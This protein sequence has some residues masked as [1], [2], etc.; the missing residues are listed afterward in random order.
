MTTSHPPRLVSIRVWGEFACVTRPELKAERV[1]YPVLTPAAA[2]GILEA[3]YFEPQMSYLIH[4]IGVVK[5]GRWFSFRRNEVSKVVSFRDAARAMDGAGHLATIQAGGGAP[6]ATQR[7][8]LALADVEYL[9][10]A[11]IRLTRRADP[12]RDNLDKYHD[13]FVH[14]ATRGKCFH[15]P[16]LGCREFDANFAYVPDPSAIQLGVAEWAKQ[17]NLGLMLY[18][19]FDPRDRDSGNSARPSPVFFEAKLRDA[20]LECHPDRVRI[21]RG[22]RPKREVIS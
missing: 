13:L 8:M 20:R 21:V 1:S 22:A 10:T 12:P 2:R 19:V 6:D 4:E 17:E 15:R 9:I 16:Y 3:V 18:D 14:R 7:G 5:R 11:E